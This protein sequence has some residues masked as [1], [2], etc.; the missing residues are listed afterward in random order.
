MDTEKV[1]ELVE[2]MKANDLNEL[3]IVDGATRIMLKRG[4]GQTVSQVVAVP[5]MLAAESIP[6]APAPGGAE[7]A[8]EKAAEKEAADKLGLKKRMIQYYETGKR[9]GK[10]VAIPKAV[11]LACF[12]LSQGVKSFNG[13]E[14]VYEEGFGGDKRADGDPDAD[15]SAH[16]NGAA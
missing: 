10:H 1:K 16:A 8:P 2:M 7:A 13:S 9:D 12:A 5:P 14:T 15:R 4:A 6:A 11:S 3:E